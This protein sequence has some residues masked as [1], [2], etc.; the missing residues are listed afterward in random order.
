MK[1]LGGSKRMTRSKG[2]GRVRLVVSAWL[3]AIVV[4][5]ATG[6]ALLTSGSASAAP[7]TDWTAYLNGPS[8]NSYNPS[9][10]S[11]TV[12]G[13]QAG[14]LQP[15]WR[16][17]PPPSPNAGP[18]TIM[19]TPVVNNGVFYVGVQDGI[20]YAVS[21]ATQQILWSDFL[22]LRTPAP[23]GGCGN[24]A[25]GIYATATV[26]PDPTT[27]VETVYVNSQDGNMYALNAATG[28]IE[29]KS[30]VDT[31]SSDGRRLLRLV[32]THRRQR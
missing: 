3:A 28:A 15:V 6:S 26:A 7:S 23:G 31:P 5:L 2:W 4:P 8:H 30:Q 19:A 32:V 10:D 14:N 12:P 18:P 11:I 13:I 27:G 16:W 29:W 21:E 1:T 17:S 20:F 24:A 22:G 25:Q 9:A